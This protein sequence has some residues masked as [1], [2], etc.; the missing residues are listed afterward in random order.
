MQKLFSVPFT[1]VPFTVVPFTVVPFSACQAPL[2]LS[3]TVEAPKWKHPVEAPQVEAPSGSAQVEVP[4]SLRYS[5]VV[6]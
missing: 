4:H 6:D 2:T 1:V 3:L 5:D